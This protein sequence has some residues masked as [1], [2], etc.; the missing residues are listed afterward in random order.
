MKTINWR[1]RSLK[2][3]RLIFFSL[4]FVSCGTPYYYYKPNASSR[5]FIKDEYQCSL[6]VSTYIYNLNLQPG[7]S[8]YDR[9]FRQQWCECMALKDWQYTESETQC[10]YCYKAHRSDS[11]CKGLQ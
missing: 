7:N 9:A 3:V 6:D 5:D 4:L 8:N 1:S 10:P 11:D 2:A